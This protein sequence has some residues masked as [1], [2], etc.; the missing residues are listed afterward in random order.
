MYESLEFI[1]LIFAIL[2]II[3]FIFVVTNKKFLV[4][5]GRPFYKNS[6]AFSLFYL[7]LAGIVLFFLLQKLTIIEIFAAAF[8]AGLLMKS[9]LIAY[10]TDFLKAA[11]KAIY[12]KNLPWTLWLE[13]I[14]WLA[15][16]VWILYTIIF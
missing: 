15:L 1:A 16:S 14:I 5:L 7:I 6:N 10:G 2:V 11:E 9:A 13:I 12:K 8:F 4:S 3:K